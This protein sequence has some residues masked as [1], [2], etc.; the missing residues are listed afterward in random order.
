[1][2]VC[3]SK[4]SVYNELEN[5]I[6]NIVQ[7]LEPRASVTKNLNDELDAMI[8]DKK[9]ISCKMILTS[10]KKLNKKFEINKNI[11]VNMLD[12]SGL[13]PVDYWIFSNPDYYSVFLKYYLTDQYPYPLN[14]KNIE[15][16]RTLIT[17][18]N[19]IEYVKKSIEF[20]AIL[21]S[22]Y[23]RK[24]IMEGINDL[25]NEKELELVKKLITDFTNHIEKTDNNLELI[26]QYYNS[27]GLDY[28]L[29]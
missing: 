22:Q 27:N 12:I 13:E 26:K 29:S 17:Y 11:L 4:Q 8:S 28:F 9:F 5:P 19:N 3:H 10:L 1:M 21:Y 15:T 23:C 14:E 6:D 7:C 18:N 20:L 25:E 16:I 2:G 24:F